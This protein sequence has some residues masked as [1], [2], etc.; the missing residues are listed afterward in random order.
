MT[1]FPEECDCCTPGVPGVKLCQKCFMVWYDSGITSAA[2]LAR[3]ARWRKANGCWPWPA[4]DGTQGRLATLE[5][6]AA[7]EH[8][9]LPDMG[10]EK[11]PTPTN[12]GKEDAV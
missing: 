3:E 9:P 6:L 7:L 12:E 5:E 11:H 8:M 10:A 1:G 2:V 4:K